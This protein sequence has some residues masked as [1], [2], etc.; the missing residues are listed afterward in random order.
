[1]VGE[2]ALT[3]RADIKTELLKE[4][5][6]NSATLNRIRR[7]PGVDLDTLGKVL[8]DLQRAGEFAHGQA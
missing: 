2:N 6:R 7:Q 4:L 1:V 8:E 3:A 5:D